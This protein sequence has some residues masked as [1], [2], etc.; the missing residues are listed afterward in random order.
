MRTLPGYENLTDDELFLA[1]HFA[2]IG[3]HAALRMFQET[4]ASRNRIPDV[5]TEPVEIPE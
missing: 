3:D 1:D 4:S 2:E 5:R